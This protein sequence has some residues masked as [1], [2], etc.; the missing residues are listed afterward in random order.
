MKALEPLRQCELHVHLGGCLFVAD[1][2]ELARDV[3]TKVDWHLFVS[4]YARAFGV[5]PDPVRLFRRALREQPG[6]LEALCRHYVF[7]DADRGDFA[8]FQAKLN[9]AICLYRHWWLAMGR[10]EEV[11]RR[12]V[13]RH[14][15]E[16]LRYVEYR[17]MAP[18]GPEHPEGFLAFHTLVARTLHH[19]S[20]RSFRARYLISVPRW[21]ALESYCLVRQLLADRPEL[22]STIV[23]LDFCFFEE[24]YP[25]AAAAPVFARVG[26]DNQAQ[27]E[28]AL[29][30]AYHVGEIYDDKSLE[31]AVRW[32]HQAAELGA[33][34]LGHAIALGLDPEIALSRRPGAHER[35]P[36]SERLAQIAYDLEHRQALEAAGVEVPVTA[37]RREQQ[38]LERLAPKTLVTRTYSAARLA[39]IRRRQDLVLARLAA[40]GTVIE[41]CPTSNLRLGDVPGPTCHPVQRFLASDVPLVIGADDPGIFAVT[42]AEEVDWVHRQSGW[43]AARLARRLGRP[44]GW[45]FGR[46]RR[47]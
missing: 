47:V 31:S 17:A 25:P 44:Q 10:E 1:L 22:V 2:L 24:G 38:D 12:I 23:G 35:E 16:G 33:R 40:L 37:L 5:T 30:I 28:R 18:Y 11:N 13:E 36:A 34:R 20:D 9:L 26:K 27:P 21:A 4:S 6:G 43:S 14:R 15:R 32:C 19:A 29:D 3:Y 42:L 39:E 8:R 46:Q 41:T 7:T 45:A